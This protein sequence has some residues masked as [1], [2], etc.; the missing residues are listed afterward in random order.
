MLQ[1]AGQTTHNSSR[2]SSIF[3]AL[4]YQ[5]QSF[6]CIKDVEPFFSFLRSSIAFSI[7]SGSSSWSQL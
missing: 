3:A 4:A 7:I 2:I 5:S 6:L 1:F